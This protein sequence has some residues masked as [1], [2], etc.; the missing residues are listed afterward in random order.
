MKIIKL[1]PTPSKSSAPINVET[2]AVHI[3]MSRLNFTEGILDQTYVQLESTIK[4]QRTLDEDELSLLG[5]RNGEDRRPLMENV[6][7]SMDRKIHSENKTSG[8]SKT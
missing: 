5:V 2:S 3:K 6:G 8:P 7:S 4:T 1:T